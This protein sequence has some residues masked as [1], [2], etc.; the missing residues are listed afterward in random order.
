MCYINLLYFK[1]V[2]TVAKKGAD[3]VD[4]GK[5][6]NSKKEDEEYNYIGRCVV[7]VWRYVCG[8]CG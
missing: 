8:A 5:S 1:I 6:G 4:S 7:W 2:K 3:K